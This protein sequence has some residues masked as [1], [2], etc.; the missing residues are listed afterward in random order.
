MAREGAK[1]TVYTLNGVVVPIP[2]HNEL[3]EIFSVDIFKE[4]KGVMGKGWWKK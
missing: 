4:R 1:H 3:G 2:C